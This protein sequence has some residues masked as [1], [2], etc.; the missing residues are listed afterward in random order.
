MSHNFSVFLSTITHPCYYSRKVKKVN[1]GP[2]VSL[3]KSETMLM[4]R[5]SLKKA[6]IS[7]ILSYSLLYS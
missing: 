4:P 6:V 2:T 3:R 7:E 1:K 5:T